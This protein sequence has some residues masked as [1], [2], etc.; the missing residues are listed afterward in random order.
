MS[1]LNDSTL[2]ILKKYRLDT[3]MSVFGNENKLYDVVKVMDDMVGNQVSK[4]V[5]N[6]PI[7]DSNSTKEVTCVKLAR[8]SPN[9][10]GIE[11]P[12]EL[13][14]NLVMNNEPLSSCPANVLVF[15][16]SSFK[17]INK[18]YLGS[19]TLCVGYAS[20]PTKFLGYI[21]VN[22]TNKTVG[23]YKD[24]SGTQLIDSDTTITNV[25]ITWYFLVFDRSLNISQTGTDYT[26]SALFGDYTADNSGTK[27]NVPKSINKIISLPEIIS[28][29]EQ[30]YIATYTQDYKGAS[31]NTNLLSKIAVCLYAT[32]QLI[33]T[34]V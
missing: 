11:R 13:T 31:S 28:S 8:Y 19:Q 34:E 10:S 16:Y 14:I 3:D 5:G 29:F 20:S 1:K 2:K 27:M 25:F 15:D 7:L 32:Q 26:V 12:R 22:F 33:I 4:Y 24:I 21:V 9:V 17:L 23:C 6:T 18:Y 30:C